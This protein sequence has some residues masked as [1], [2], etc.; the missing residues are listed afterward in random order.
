LASCDAA[1]SP[2]PASDGDLQMLEWTAAR[3]GPRLMGLVHHTDAAREWA[4]DR[5]SSIGKL[6]EALRVAR[7]QGWLVVDMKRDWKRIYPFELAAGRMDD[8]GERNAE[9][10]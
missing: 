8:K 3:R 6:D 9:Q 2:G 4:Y 10:R 5:G 1:S 7:A